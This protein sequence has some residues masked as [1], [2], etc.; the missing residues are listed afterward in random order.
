RSYG[1][2]ICA[3]RSAVV[4]AVSNRKTEFLALALSCPDSE[5]PVPP[6]GACRQV[7]SEFVHPEFPIY[8]AGK[9]GDFTRTTMKDLLPLDSLHE[10][11]Q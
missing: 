5:Y 10:L 3:E 1:L 6:C 7:L 9:D 4:S 8:F 11:R 2:T